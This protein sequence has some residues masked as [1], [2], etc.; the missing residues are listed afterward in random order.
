MTETRSSG[1]APLG[2]ADVRTLLAQVNEV[3]IARGKA[4]RRQ[5]ARET[6]LDDLRG[7]T[8]GFR[9]PMAR[10]GKTLLV[11]FSEPE[12]RKLFGA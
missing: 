7:P 2:D 12:L 3:I 4:A 9:A 11:G 1:K 10:R 8:G 6:S 5:P